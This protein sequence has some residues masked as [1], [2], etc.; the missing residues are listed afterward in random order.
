MSAVKENMIKIIKDLPED[1]SY[2]EIL[3]ELAFSKMVYQGLEDSDSER[4]IS[5]EKM[6]KKI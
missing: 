5:H 4:I 1:C 2:D 3:R 6:K